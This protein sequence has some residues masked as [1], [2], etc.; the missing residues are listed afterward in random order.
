MPLIPA[1]AEAVSE[2]E[3]EAV[4]AEADMAPEVTAEAILKL[5]VGA[6]PEESQPPQSPGLSLTPKKQRLPPSL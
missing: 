1:A 3:D 2:G 5:Q 6:A 4:P